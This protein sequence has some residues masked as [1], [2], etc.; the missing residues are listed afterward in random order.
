MTVPVNCYHFLK[1][2]IL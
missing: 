2:Y 1:W